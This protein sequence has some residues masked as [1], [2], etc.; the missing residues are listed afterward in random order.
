V[1]GQLWFSNFYRPR[2]T[3]CCGPRA[4]RLLN[5]RPAL[6][7]WAKLLN[8]RTLVVFYVHK[9][10]FC[11]Y[12]AYDI[13]IN[14][15]LNTPGRK[16]EIGPLKTSIGFN[17]DSKRGLRHHNESLPIVETHLVLLPESK[18]VLDIVSNFQAPAGQLQML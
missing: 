11:H 3:Y 6:V 16:F 2:N 18:M 9:H 4:V 8:Y 7:A 14:R 5:C 13:N 15:K 1:V 10:C 17:Y 12:T